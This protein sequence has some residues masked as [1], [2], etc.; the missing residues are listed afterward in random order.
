M[1]DGT[2]KRDTTQAKYSTAQRRDSKGYVASSGGFSS[3]A[4]IWGEG[5]T[6][7]SP[8]VLFFFFSKWRLVCTH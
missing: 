2:M 3:L 1:S 6:I 5:S 4:R 8:S 7:H